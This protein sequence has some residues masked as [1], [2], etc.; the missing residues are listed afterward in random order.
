MVKLIEM[1]SQ[2][3]L[4]GLINTYAQIQ[5]VTWTGEKSLSEAMM[6]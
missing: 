6:T 5:M 3:V 1:S 4:E 2:F